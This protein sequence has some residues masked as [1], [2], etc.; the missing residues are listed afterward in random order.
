MYVIRTNEY[1]YTKW[2]RNMIVIVL[3]NLH[4]TPRPYLSLILI[5]VRGVNG[6]T[7]ATM[8]ISGFVS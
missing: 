8:V 3:Y 4:T 1:R 2:K 7:V 5:P 6:V